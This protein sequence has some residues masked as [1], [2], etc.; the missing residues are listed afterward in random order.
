MLSKSRS[1][2]VRSLHQKKF[3][4]EHGQFLVEGAKSVQDVLASYFQV[5]LLLA[6]EAFT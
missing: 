1:Q 5:D 6:T 2:F 3:R 4:Q